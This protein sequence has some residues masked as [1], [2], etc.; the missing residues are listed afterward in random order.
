MLAWIEQGFIMTTRG[1]KT[2]EKRRNLNLNVYCTVYTLLPPCDSTY[3]ERRVAREF[4][5][6]GSETRMIISAC[7]NIGKPSYFVVFIRFLGM[8]VLI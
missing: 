8:C 1:K 3:E 7:I 5:S 2:R 4:K 6:V